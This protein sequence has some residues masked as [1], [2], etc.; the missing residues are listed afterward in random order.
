MEFFRPGYWSGEP[1]SPPEDLPN[2]GIKPRSPALETDSLPA[3]P[4]GKP[5]WPLMLTKIYVSNIFMVT[6]NWITL[7][8]SKIYVSNIFM[9]T[10]KWITLGWSQHGIASKRNRQTSKALENDEPF[11]VLQKS[12]KKMERYSYIKLSRL[13]LSFLP[14]LP[15]SSYSLAAS[16]NL[17]S[18][19]F[20]LKCVNFLPKRF[21]KI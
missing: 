5:L 7:G 20:P 8:W 2:P 12:S 17:P 1:F 11:S 6:Y 16:L 3:E 15:K 10:Y 18:V 4:Q 13:H 9:V 19:T 21:L 14:S